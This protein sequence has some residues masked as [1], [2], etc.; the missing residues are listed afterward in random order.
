MQYLCARQDFPSLSR[1]DLP[2]SA[3]NK[4][5]LY[6]YFYFQYL[7]NNCVQD[8]IFLR[9]QGGTFPFQRRISKN[10]IIIFIFNIY[11]IIVCK[12]GFSFVFNAG[13]SLFIPKLAQI[14]SIL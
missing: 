6:Y 5:K 9:Y 11:A 13:P 12:T 4:Q 7:C 8:R 3:Q 1:R 10:Y 14:Y 2:F